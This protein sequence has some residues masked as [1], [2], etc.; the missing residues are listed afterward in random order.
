MPRKG[1]MGAYIS[2]LTDITG[3]RNIK[4][5]EEGQVGKV[6]RGHQRIYVCKDWPS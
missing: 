6:Q 5:I 3:K 2:R 1:V 4:V